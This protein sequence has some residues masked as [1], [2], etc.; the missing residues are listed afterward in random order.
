MK[1]SLQSPAWEGERNSRT[2]GTL[3]DPRSDPL[4]EFS[5]YLLKKSEANTIV[6]IVGKE[7]SLFR[8]HFRLSPLKTLHAKTTVW[9]VSYHG[10]DATTSQERWGCC[11][12]DVVRI[13]RIDPISTDT[14]TIHGFQVS[15]LDKTLEL[16]APVRMLPID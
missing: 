7:Y 12:S 1:P 11:M 9:W 6:K 14:R 3:K 16:F 15:T 5:G 13:S 2:F 4:I 10:S 8:R